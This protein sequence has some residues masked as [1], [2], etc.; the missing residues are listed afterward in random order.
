MELRQADWSTIHDVLAQ[1]YKTWSAGM[2]KYQHSHYIWWQVN[3][4]WARKNYRTYV[5]MHEGAIVSSCKLYTLIFQSRSRLYTLGGIGAVHTPES[6]RN[7]GY[8]S[9]MMKE[10]IQIGKKEGM[11]AMLLHSDIDPQFY[12]R[13]GFE[14]MG[15][16]AVHIFPQDVKPNLGDDIE[17]LLTPERQQF[18]EV[19]RAAL[20]DVDSMVRH[21]G[22]W[23]PN[24]P[25]AVKR[26][27][28]YFSFK[29]A[30]EQYVQTYSHRPWP[31]IELIAYKFDSGEGGYALFEQSP[32]VM[33]ILEVIGSRSTCELIWLKIFQL[34]AAGS[35][36]LIRCWEGVEP[37]FLAN[38]RW[39]ER[40]WAL[41]MLL[42]LNPVTGS[43]PGAERCPLLEM[44]HF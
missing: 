36:R 38:E 29:L 17:R 26:D 21:H 19:R 24:Q 35:K 15:S 11:D 10:I 27:D 1:T 8:A 5:L 40:E 34:A 18:F 25:F 28:V 32:D 6:Q 23:L 31:P 22:R 4:P 7:C 43:W 3:H 41:P 9:A 44:D 2:D 33:R 20:A 14:E 16:H 30:K 37:H 39:L 42:P 12:G 13:L